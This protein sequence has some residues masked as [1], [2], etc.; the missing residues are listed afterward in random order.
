MGAIIL[1][2]GT[3]LPDLLPHVPVL[4]TWMSREALPTLFT[5][6]V[7]LRTI[8]KKGMRSAWHG[9][10]TLPASLLSR[11]VLT[12][13]LFNKP[14]GQFS[15]APSNW[16]A[17]PYSRNPLIVHSFIENL[18]TGHLPPGSEHFAFHSSRKPS[19]LHPQPGQP[20]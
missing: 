18:A 20:H 4:S 15:R 5:P 2:P 9:L 10:F 13:H 8:S 14:F 7:C 19:C 16:A 3:Q 6:S 12:H 1:L 11:C 17:C